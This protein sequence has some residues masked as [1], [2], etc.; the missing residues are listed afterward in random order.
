MDEP[1]GENQ[2]FITKKIFNSVK[3]KN[4]NKNH[5]LEISILS[6]LQKHLSAMLLHFET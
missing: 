4:K 2:K 5:P 6:L 3:T 1:C